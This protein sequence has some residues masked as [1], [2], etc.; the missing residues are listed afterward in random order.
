[1][2]GA[3]LAGDAVS[4]DT[5]SGAL[6]NWQQ[7]TLIAPLYTGVGGVLDPNFW[8]DSK[9]VAGSVLFYDATYI[10]ILADGE[11]VSTSDNCTAVVQFYDGT[12][13]VLGVIVIVP[14]LVGYA[15]SVSVVA[16]TLTAA[17][18]MMAAAQELVAVAGALTAH[19]TLAAHATSVTNATAALAAKIKLAG[20]IVT[21]DVISASL[22]SLA[23][24][25]SPGD[26]PVTSVATGD[27]TTAIQFAASA[28]DVAQAAGNLSTQI[29][30]AAHAL[31]AASLAAANL[32]TSTA[33]KAAAISGA[34]AT[35]ALLTQM[36]LAGPAADLVAAAGSLS[37]SIPLLGAGVSASSAA[38]QLISQLHL[39]TAPHALAQASAALSTI[40]SMQGVAWAAT[41]A[42]GTLTPIAAPLGGPAISGSSASGDLLAPG[43]PIGLYVYDP[44]FV[45][46]DAR[47]D[48]TFKFLQIGPGEAHVLSFDFSTAADDDQT[49][50]LVGT[51]VLQGIIAVAVECTSGSDDDPMALLNGAASYDPTQ[52]LVMQPVIGPSGGSGNTYYITVTAPTS[53]PQKI[54]YRFGLLPVQA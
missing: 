8:L 28:T 46:T 32:K 5:V 36:R 18:H 51:E 31:A 10:T 23:L 47:E 25:S 9:P 21:A 14:T 41:Y 53:N 2:S 35:G 24:A 11:I 29:A 17:N 16:G 50:T 1:M 34:V 45:S 40:V 12:Q 48:F 43:S 37:T 3:A 54:L 49:A 42:K 26:T 13:W 15:S 27:L 33:L 52:K 22:D 20:H 38:G 19:I 44:F 4:G 6:T 39:A 7:V 30:L